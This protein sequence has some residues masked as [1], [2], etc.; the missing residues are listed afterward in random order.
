MEIA[1]P[2]PNVKKGATVASNDSRIKED[3]ELL[4]KDEVPN[5]DTI[6]Q[7]PIA[8]KS[9]IEILAPKGGNETHRVVDS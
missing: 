9:A 1:T 3:P 4:P 2:G 6:V 7:A 5:E 8:A